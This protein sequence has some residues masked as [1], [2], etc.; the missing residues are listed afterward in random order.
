MMLMLKVIMTESRSH[1]KTREIPTKVGTYIAFPKKKE[2]HTD[3]FYKKTSIE[4]S[5]Y[6]RIFRLHIRK[7]IQI[8]VLKTFLFKK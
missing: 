4:F 5:F 8:L 3:I 7:I 6:L 2:S 1:K